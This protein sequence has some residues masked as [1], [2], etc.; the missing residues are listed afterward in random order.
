MPEK[1]LEGVNH[2]VEEHDAGADEFCTGAKNEAQK[3][4][5]H[6][7]R[8]IDMSSEFCHDFP[9]DI[10]L[11]GSAAYLSNRFPKTA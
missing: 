5:S 3:K 8:F 7:I 9:P 1:I 4:N 6:Q 10:R 11:Y 2:N